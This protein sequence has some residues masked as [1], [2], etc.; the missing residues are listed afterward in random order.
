MQPSEEIKAKL[1]I[2]E[3]IRDYI[4]LQQAGS[5]W[6]AKCPFLPEKSPGFMVSAEKQ[7]WCFFGCGKGGDVFSFIQEIEGVEFIEALRLLAPKAGVALKAMDPKLTSKRNRLLDILDPSRRYY[8]KVLLESPAA[9]KAR[10][11]LSARG[12]GAENLEEWQIGYSPDSWDI[13]FN[14]LKSKGFSENEIFLAGMVVRRQ[15]RPGF[16]DR[17][18]GRIMFPINDVNGA[19]VAFTARGAP[20]KG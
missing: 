7:S 13:T 6:R 5:N 15:N 1:D 11:Y 12:L 3:V 10:Q 14:L 17:F 4:Q 2:V 19:T 8:H 16:Y 9:E 18:R 20:A